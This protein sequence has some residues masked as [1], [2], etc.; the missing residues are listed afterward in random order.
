[1]EKDIKK[2]TTLDISLA[3]FFEVRGVPADLEFFKERVIFAFPADDLLYTLL[4]EF[5]TNAAVNI[6]DYVSTLRA[7]K[8]KLLAMKNSESLSVR[9]S[10][11]LNGKGV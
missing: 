4:R 6:T 1:M 10:G 11:S 7:L 9:L 5:N 8:G 3:A 2:F